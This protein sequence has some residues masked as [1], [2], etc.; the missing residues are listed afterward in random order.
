MSSVNFDALAA[1]YPKERETIE[2]LSAL[3]REKRSGELSFEH[4]VS[5]LGPK[6]VEALA[7]VLGEL[8]EAGLFRRTIRIESPTRGGGI[9]DFDSLEHVPSHIFDWRAAS[10]IEVTPRNL[11]VVYSVAE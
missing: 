1:E 3:V 9:G 6:S 11:R 7:L 2:R 4:L 8:V 5:K 10:E